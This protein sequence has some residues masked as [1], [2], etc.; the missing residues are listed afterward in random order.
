MPFCVASRIV[1]NLDILRTMI[2][3]KFYVEIILLTNYNS[4]KPKYLVNLFSGRIEAMCARLNNKIENNST[5]KGAFYQNESFYRFI[6]V[7]ELK[8]TQ[9]ELF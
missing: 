8:L 2:S 4:Y 5:C 9:V 3:T 1:N 7:N 6:K